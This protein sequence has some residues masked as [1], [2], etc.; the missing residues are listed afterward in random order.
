MA[1]PRA[2]AYLPDMTR[3]AVALAGM[4]ADLPA[5]S[6]VPFAG[7]TFSMDEVKTRL[8][9][10]L[11]RELK[12]GRFP[13]GAMR[14]AAPFWE[15]ARELGEMRYLYDLPHALDPAP[16]ARLLPD[17]R[18]TDLDRVLREHVARLVDQGSASVT[19]TGA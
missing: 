8:E 17:F 1:V 15:L 11:G 5:F 10:I 6:D 4:R 19:Q 3:A 14:L 7:L 2:W 13:W 16:M 9:A 12:V 18:V